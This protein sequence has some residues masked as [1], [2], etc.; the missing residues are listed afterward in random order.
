MVIRSYKDLVVWQ[1]AMDMA[2]QVCLASQRFP[3]HQRYVMISQLQRCA[4]SVPSNIA[5]GYARG[6]DKELMRFLNI[7]SGSLCEVETQLILSESLGFVSQKEMQDLT[8]QV[9]E[10]MKLLHGF[11]RTVAASM[12]HGF[13]E[14]EILPF[15]A[16]AIDAN[17]YLLTAKG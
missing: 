7:A 12:N 8:E 2:K 11:K 9:T 4:I 1:K 6:S 5:E 16:E 3:E 15:E 17:R 14:A 13:A 10:V